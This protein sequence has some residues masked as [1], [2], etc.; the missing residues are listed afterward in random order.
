MN[1]PAKTAVNTPCDADVRFEQL[2]YKVHSTGK[3]GSW[4]IS[5]TLNP[6]A[7]ATMLV[8]A[9]KVLG[10]KGVETLTEYTE[11]KNIGR[12]NE[13]T[14]IM[15]AVFEAQSKVKKQLDKG[16][17]EEKPEEGANV[18]NAL[19]LVKPMLA[20]PVEKVKNWQ[21]PVHVQPKMDGHRCL[22]T[23][24]DGKVFLYSRGGKP[25]IVHHIMAALQKLA[26]SG[27][28]GG[29]T[30]D[31][32]LYCHGKAFE[33]ISSLIKK[34]QQDSKYLSYNIY[35]I[36]LEAPYGVR[37]DVL[38]E[39][40]T[41]GEY[42]TLCLTACYQVID[43]AGI[44]RYHAA[45]TQNGYEG[46]MIRHG[47]AHYETDKRSSSLMK[48]KDEKDAEFEIVGVRKGK[49]NKRLG[50][51]VGIYICK[52]LDGKLFDVTAPGDAKEKHHHAVNGHQNIGKK[53]TVF[54]FGYTKEGKPCHITNS[55]IRE[56]L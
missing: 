7:T 38:D 44:D 37:F 11:G 34:P 19:G 14:P 5:V 53:L 1:I 8:T 45:W 56:D 24:Q 40:I 12:S 4:H 33:N 16:Y 28:W 46:T 47:H 48:R 51:E 55:R 9:C 2:L 26:D 6:D 49:P 27:R 42:P 54:S 17:V 25:I 10:G 30:L 43:Q 35:D 31:G 22:A 39:L 50:T 52:T 23:L 3:I 41:E 36:V 13:T 18:T 32:E 15:Q 20:Q 21:F 29:E